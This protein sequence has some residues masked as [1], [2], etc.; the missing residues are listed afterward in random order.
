MVEFY[1]IEKLPLTFDW[2]SPS[3]ELKRDK[4]SMTSPLR[5][6]SRAPARAGINLIWDSHWIINNLNNQGHSF[7]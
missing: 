6:P 4:L 5:H 7:D 3:Y 1:I 2:Q